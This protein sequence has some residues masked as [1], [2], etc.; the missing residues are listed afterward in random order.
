MTDTTYTIAT[1]TTALTG[2]ETIHYCSP[3]EYIKRANAR[4]HRRRYEIDLKG[5]VPFLLSRVDVS[6]DISDATLDAVIADYLDVIE[7]K[8]P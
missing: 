3:P 5:F 1:T 4:E 6:T 7:P 2:G 8:N